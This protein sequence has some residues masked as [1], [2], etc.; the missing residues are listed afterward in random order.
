MRIGDYNK[1]VSL[2][3]RVIIFVIAVIFL[4]PVFLTI[5]ESF[6]YGGN[7][8]FHGYQQLFLN[9]FPFYGLFW[10]SVI[11][12][13]IIT[14]GTLIICVPAAFAFKFAHFR[15]KNLLYVIYI[16]IM[17]MPLQVMIL[18]NYIGLRD[19]GFLYTRLAIIVP[20]IFTPFGVVV[21]H[22]YM[23]EIDYS[24]IESA[25]LETNSVLRVIIHCIIPQIKVCIAAVALFVYAD[26]W[27]M[28]EQPMLYVDD[29]KLRTLSTFI[30]QADN[31]SLEVMLPASVLYLVPVFL[32][33]LLFHEELKQGLKL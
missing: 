3:I 20:M 21:T 12:T 9:C 6:Y 11:Y 27:N 30:T 13:V 18:P 24:V 22:Q 4:V 32:C 5:L 15:G 16:I 8:S 26:T 2:I 10:N 29:D 28:V 31:Y 17:M 23:R 7:F 19:M 1:F 33:Y 25:R 14:T